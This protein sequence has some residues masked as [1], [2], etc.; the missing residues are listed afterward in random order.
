MIMVTKTKT[1][2]DSDVEDMKEQ[3]KSHSP[4]YNEED[5]RELTDKVKQELK[6]KLGC[7]EDK[8]KKCTIDENVVIHYKTDRCDLE[9]KI[10]ENGVPYETRRYSFYVWCSGYE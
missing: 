1:Q 9:E 7:S 4:E 10:Y 2:K 3:D 5:I 8:L 6:G